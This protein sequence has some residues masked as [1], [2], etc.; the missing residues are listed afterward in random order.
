MAMA[1]RLSANR[2]LLEPMKNWLSIERLE[3]PQRPFTTITNFLPQKT[4]HLFDR[5]VRCEPAPSDNEIEDQ[6]LTAKGAKNTMQATRYN[7][8][9]IKRT[10]GRSFRGRI[11]CFTAIACR[12]RLNLREAAEPKNEPKRQVPNLHRQPQVLR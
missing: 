8:K 5:T 4:S 11:T 10:Q 2:L 3:V 6:N 12:P 9:L 7:K 1:R